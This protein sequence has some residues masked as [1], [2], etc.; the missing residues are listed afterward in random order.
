MIARALLVAILAGLTAGLFVT[1]VQMVRVT[2]LILEAEIYE[3][4]AAHDQATGAGGAADAA[5]AAATA[6][7]PWAPD[8]G[9]ERTVYTLLA[10]ILTG[11]GFGLL[12][13]AVFTLRGRPV[14]WREGVLWGLG[15]FAVF[16]LAPAVGLPPELPGTAAAD[17]IERQI[18]WAAP[19]RS[20]SA[21]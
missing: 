14:G 5:A 17:L 19:I 7:E 13:A 18:W 11:V 16:A 4:G 21:S 9:F 2:P 20:Q 1:A 10:N 8:D 6:D 15:G 3:S 12:L